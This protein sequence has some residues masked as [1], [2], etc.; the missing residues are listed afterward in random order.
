MIH[1]LAVSGSL[2]AA[3][4]NTALLRAAA[5]LAPPDIAIDLFD[6]IAALPHFNPDLEHAMPPAV[7]AWL[8]QLGRCDGVLVACPE[9]AHGIPGAFKNALDWI[10]GSAELTP[11][12]VV[13]INTAPRA[14]HAQA[15]LAEVVATMGWTILATPVISIANT[16][17][18]AAALAADPALAAQIRATIDVFRQQRA[19]A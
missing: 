4:T 13:L 9:Y 14:R 7:Q 8:A 17:S 3:S 1:L 19:G 15:A 12:N 10:V 2:R 5:A 6:G 18:D 16:G 11:K